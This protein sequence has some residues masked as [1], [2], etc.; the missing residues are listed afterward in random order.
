MGGR[1]TRVG[2]VLPRMYSRRDGRIKR[3]RGVADVSSCLAMRVCVGGELQ[4]CHLGQCDGGN[5]ARQQM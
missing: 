1:E 5:T 2:S 4:V 3:R